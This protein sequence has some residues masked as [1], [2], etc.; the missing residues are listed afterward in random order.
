MWLCGEKELKSKIN[1][2][3]KL[4]KAEQV[5]ARVTD[6]TAD[7]EEALDDYINEQRKQHRGCGKQRGHEQAAR[8]EA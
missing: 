2:N 1:A 4:S 3:P 7:I 5:H 6:S 8:G